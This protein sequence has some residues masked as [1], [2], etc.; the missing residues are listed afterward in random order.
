[1][2]IYTERGSEGITFGATAALYA[3]G[4]QF[5]DPK[6][7]YR[8]EG[9]V[10]S[11]QAVEALEFYKSL[12]KCCTPPG[13]TNAY[14]TE[15]LDA[16]KSGQVAMQMNWFAF[17]LGIARDPNVGGARSG[18]F[19]NPSQK[20]AASTLGGQAIVVVSYSDK[21][22][23]ALQYIKWFAQAE[24]QKKWW[25]AGG[26]STHKAVLLDR[27]FAKSTPFAGE[28]L[29]ALRQGKYFRQ[30]E[31]FVPLLLYSQKRIHDYVVADKGTARQALDLLIK[32]W[33]Q[34]FEEDGIEVER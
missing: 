29:R 5:E 26:F 18:F 31:G 24:V 2:A 33:T 11:P 32:D 3:W 30:Y 1:V 9:F 10:N 27:N 16:Y 34:V 7:P 4:F 25:A 19:A 28:Y 8:M 14:M 6:K 22:E 17:F 21:K 23:Q 15:N 20:M 13:H 12:F